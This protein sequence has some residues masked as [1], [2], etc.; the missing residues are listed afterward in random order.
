MAADISH[1]ATIGK[2]PFDQSTKHV[3]WLFEQKP[4]WQAWGNSIIPRSRTA[5]Y[6]VSDEIWQE[7]QLI[8]AW[9]H[10]LVTYKNEK[11]QTKNEVERVVT[12]LLLL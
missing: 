12:T 10:V 2:N 9:M 7:F 11:D 4:N 1:G 3:P 8:Q 6:V 5:N